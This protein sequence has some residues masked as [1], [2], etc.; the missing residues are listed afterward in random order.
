[1]VEDFYHYP[2]LALIM[3]GVGVT[4]NLIIYF[5]IYSSLEKHACEI[6]QKCIQ[7]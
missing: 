4:S 7:F 1:M 5:L 6:L 2:L 3:A